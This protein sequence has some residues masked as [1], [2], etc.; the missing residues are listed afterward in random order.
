M[1]ER[2]DGSTYLF[3]REFFFCTFMGTSLD[4]GWIHGVWIAALAA[5]AFYFSRE[6]QVDDYPRDGDM[7]IS[8]SI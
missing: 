3:I 7:G 1:S 4:A 6:S 5:H 8:Q 2:F